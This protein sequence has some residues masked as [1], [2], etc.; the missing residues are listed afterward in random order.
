MNYYTMQSIMIN[1]DQV[2]WARVCDDRD[3]QFD[4]FFVGGHKQMFRY[5]NKEAMFVEFV[6]LRSFVQAR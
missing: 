3:D 2:L 4:V 5:A 6:K 1:L